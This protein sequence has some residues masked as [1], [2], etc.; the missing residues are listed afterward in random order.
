MLRQRSAT[1]CSAVA[2]CCSARI[3]LACVFAISI[4]IY[5]GGY[6]Q[7]ALAEESPYLSGNWGGLRDRLN[8]HGL[9]IELVATTDLMVLVSGGIERGLETPANFD[10]VFTLDTEAAGWW[11][12]GSFILYFLGNA[13]GNP[14]SRLGDLQVASNIEAVNTFKLYEVSYEHHFVDDNVSLLVGL[15]DLNSEFYVLEHASLFLN[16]S[17]GIGVEVAQT[18]PSIFSTT[19]LAARLRARWRNDFYLM[20]AVYDG[21]PGDPED[22]IGTQISFDEGDGIFFI[23]ETGMVRDTAGYSKIGIGAWYHTARYEDFNGRERN[24]NSGIYLIAERDLWRDEAGR[25]LGLF[26]QAGF[27]EGDRNQINTYLGGG[28]TWTGLVPQRPNDVAGVAV[29]H[30]R[31]GDKFRRL[32]P[33]MERAETAIE[34]SYLFSPTAW[35]NVQPDIQYIIGPGSDRDLDNGLVLGVRLQISI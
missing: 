16:S 10:I 22:A 12:N 9:D 19:A 1:P 28:L 2:L 24:S 29:A 33:T 11:N 25:G 20:T 4:A 13:G 31:N 27:A 17:F 7:I 18:G 30:A 8:A 26:A 34:F 35:M 21:I 6:S 3:I 32:N 14:S 15:H 5:C 23:A